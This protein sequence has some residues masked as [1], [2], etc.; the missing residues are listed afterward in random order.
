MQAEQVI[1]EQSAET[2]IL[3]CLFH[4]A[5]ED[6]KE[7]IS[8]IREDHFFVHEHKIIFNSASMRTTS[9]SRTSLRATSS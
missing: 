3:S 5:V 2:A 9:T 1:Y 8:T 6:Q 4:G 7:I